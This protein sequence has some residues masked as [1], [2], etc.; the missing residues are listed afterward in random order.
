[1]QYKGSIFSIN[2]PAEENKEE[3]ETKGSRRKAQKADRGQ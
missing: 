1:M 2:T 3:R